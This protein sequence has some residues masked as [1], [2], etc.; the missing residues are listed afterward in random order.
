MDITTKLS[1]NQWTFIA[2]IPYVI[3]K[4]WLLNYALLPD[5]DVLINWSH[6]LPIL[7]HLRPLKK[8]QLGWICCIL[9]QLKKNPARIR[10]G[11]HLIACISVFQ[12]YDNIHTYIH[13]TYYSLTS[14]APLLASISFCFTISSKSGD[15]KKLISL[16]TFDSSGF[17]ASETMESKNSSMATLNSGCC[18]K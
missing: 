6:N 13:Y 5:F 8:L 4:L 10:K 2:H 14:S 1:Y 18:S 9:L 15:V 17:G 3:M 7:T 11:I 12:F 16:S